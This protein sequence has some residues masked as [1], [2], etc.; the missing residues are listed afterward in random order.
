VIAQPL[1]S[2]ARQVYVTA[3]A[4]PRAMAAADV[5]RALEMPRRKDRG[6]GPTRHRNVRAAIDVARSG[7]RPGEVV[8]VT[9]SLALVG[10]ARAA[11]GLA[12]PERLWT[13]G[14]GPALGGPG[15]RARKS[16]PRTPT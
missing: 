7:A 2:L 16:V 8:V 5:A 15:D 1:L 11:I 6:I 4:G 9:G 12:I 3:A 14:S 10:E 13:R